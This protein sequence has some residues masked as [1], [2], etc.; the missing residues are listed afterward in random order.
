MRIKFDLVCKK[1][2]ELPPPTVDCY[3]KLLYPDSEQEKTQSVI[4]WLGSGKI[5]DRA[6]IKAE[7]IIRAEI[8]LIDWLRKTR[9]EE[10]Y[11]APHISTDVHESGPYTTTYHEMKFVSDYTGMNFADIRLLDVLQ[12]WR[13][14]RD[15]I[16]YT[17]IQ[18]DKGKEY[19][20]NAYNSVQTKPDRA[21]IAE[22]IESQA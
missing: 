6:Y 10:K 3:Y 7:D 17:S 12:F 13:Y 14:Y 8:F 5:E 4:E 16:I 20:K 19:L 1:H 15:A 11:T 9:K 2:I 18:S 21:A 22:L